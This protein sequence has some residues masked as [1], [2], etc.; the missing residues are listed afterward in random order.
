MGYVLHRALFVVYMSVNL[1]CTLVMHNFFKCIK[2]QLQFQETIA[3]YMQLMFIILKLTLYTGKSR[4]F[5][6]VVTMLLVKGL[7]VSRRLMDNCMIGIRSSLRKRRQKRR[8][9]IIY[10]SKSEERPFYHR[11]FQQLEIG[12]KLC[13]VIVSTPGIRIF[14]I[15]LPKR[16]C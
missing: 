4:F 10:G 6:S 13:L 14:S 5:S 15:F 11:Q 9:E 7:I 16:F 12:L 3:A 8:Q 1:F 2:L